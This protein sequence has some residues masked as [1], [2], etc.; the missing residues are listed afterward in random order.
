M[1]A[2]DTAAHHLG[3]NLLQVGQ[4]SARLA[5]VVTEPHRNSHQICHG[6]V[7]FTLADSAFAGAQ[8]R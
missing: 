2:R 7:I 3:I 6:G 1:W 8:T 5:L 4:N